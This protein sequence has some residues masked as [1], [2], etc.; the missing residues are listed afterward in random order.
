MASFFLL[1]VTITK[2]QNIEI[3]FHHFDRKSTKTR[4]QKQVF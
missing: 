3:G 4:N 2:E 1:L